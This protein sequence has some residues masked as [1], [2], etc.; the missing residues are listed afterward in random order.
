[1]SNRVRVLIATGTMNAGGAES[2]IM[3]ILR[4]SSGE[5]EFILL[6]H[7]AGPISP[8][9]YDDEI[10]KIGVPI[11]FIP[12]V[13]SI[14]EYKYIEI[15]KERISEIGRVDIIHSH[16]NAV[17]GIIAKAAKTAGIKYRIIHCHADITYRGNRIS[18]L[19]NEARLQIM[20]IF[21]N[22][23]GTSFWACSEPAARRLFFRNKTFKIIPNVIDV[24]KY[25]P[26]IDKEKSAKERLSLSGRTIL[27][28]VGRIAPIKNYEFIIKIL[29]Q[30]KRQNRLYDFVCY[31]RVVDE[32]YYKRVLDIAK[33]YDVIKQVHFLGNSTNIHDDIAAFDVYLMPSYSEGFGISAVEAQAAGLPTIVSTGVPPLVDVGLE[34]VQFL[35]LEEETWVEAIIKSLDM[36]KP[37]KDRI[38]TA[39]NNHNLNSANTVREIEREYLRIASC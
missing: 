37:K 13:G 15:F 18:K 3:E 20:K 10:R 16:L 8:G 7:H 30:L 24:E 4:H 32:V 19:F 25:L 17:G 33:E 11:V 38:I 34:I 21:V 23:Y 1:M 39:F 9:V 12:S 27:G 22:R 28:A 29:Y 26:D 5:V 14:G 2:L 35:P 31:G 6:I 36:K